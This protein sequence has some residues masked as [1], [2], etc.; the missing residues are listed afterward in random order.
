MIKIRSDV[1][2]N[3]GDNQTCIVLIQNKMLAKCQIFTVCKFQLTLHRLLELA[4]LR[5]QVAD[6]NFPDET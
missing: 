3:I 6:G 1:D 4:M 2:P 5:A